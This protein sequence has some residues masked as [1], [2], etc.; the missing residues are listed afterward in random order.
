VSVVSRE[1][2]LSTTST[3]GS[4]DVDELPAG[5][6]GGG[7]RGTQRIGML[8]EAYIACARGAATP[9]LASVFV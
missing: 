3:C 4:G 8:Q 9:S 7:E 6:V 5:D 2:S 1:C